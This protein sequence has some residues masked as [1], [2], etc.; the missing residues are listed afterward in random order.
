MTTEAIPRVS[1]CMPV[2]RGPERFGRALHS[3]LNQDLQDF[4]ILV[5]DE[6]GSIEALAKRLGD[7]R[8]RYFRNPERLGFAR[9]HASL[10]DRAHGSYLTVLHDDDRWEPTFLSSLVRIL[11]EDPEVG[12][13]LSSTVIDHEDEQR[14]A[15]PRWPTKLAAGRTDDVLDVLLTEEWFMLIDA[16]VWRREVWSGEARTWPA[17]RCADLHFF[18]SAA[19]AGWPFHYLDAP[20]THY[21]I[22]REQSGARRGADHGLA[23]AEE[24]LTFW[25]QWL[26]G[27]PAVQSELSARQRAGWHVRRARALILAGRPAEARSALDEAEALGGADVPELRRYR[28]AAQIPTPVVLAG[29]TVRRAASRVSSVAGR[30]GSTRRRDR[31]ETMTVPERLS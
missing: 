27:R 3:V 14:S 8:I 19:E 13:A 1:V 29:V 6:T 28:R 26:D 25:N 21:S 12:L 16:A 23:V 20:L 4:E 7:L 22:H 24:V 2:A 5:G 30:F 18:L 15:P 10:L 31:M 9:N 17:L 11:D